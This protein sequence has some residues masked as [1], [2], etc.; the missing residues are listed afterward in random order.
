MIMPWFLPFAVG[1]GVVGTRTTFRN[2]HALR[3]KRKD[4]WLHLGLAWIPLLAW[5]ASQVVR[6]Y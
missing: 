1:I 3:A 6:Q 4:W 2:R 5:A